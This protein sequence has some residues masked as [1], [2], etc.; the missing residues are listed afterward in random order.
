LLA[1]VCVILFITALLTIKTLENYKGDL[2]TKG[3]Y[4]KIRHPMYL[5]FILWSIGFPVYYG[6]LFSFILSFLFIANILFW[7]YLE[8][9]DLENRF[10]DYKEYKK[11]TIF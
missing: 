7:R 10:P 1:I 9:I 8:E 3:V 6:A 2:I 11:K 4:S 5:G